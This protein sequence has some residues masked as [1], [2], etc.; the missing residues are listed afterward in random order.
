MSCKEISLPLTIDPMK[1]SDLPEIMTIERESFLSPWTANMFKRELNLEQS[2][3]LCARIPSDGESL[4][5]GYIIFWLIIDEAHLH[6]LAV[7]KE[8]RKQGIAFR[9]MEAMNNI[10]GENEMIFQTLEVRASNVDAIKL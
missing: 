5:V 1:K 4:V 9:L 2:L 7:K 10:A 6:N 8:Y 3:C